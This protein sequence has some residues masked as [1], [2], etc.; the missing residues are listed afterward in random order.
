[1][2]RAATQLTKALLEYYPKGEFH[3]FCGKGN[4]GG[5]G[6]AVA[7]MLFEKEAPVK[8]YVVEHTDNASED[9]KSNLKAASELQIPLQYI[10]S[11]SEIPTVE[12]V[13]VDAL[14]GSGLN[15]PLEGLLKSVVAELNQQSAI[16]VAIDI[17]TG[18]FAD[19]NQENE[20]SAVYKADR[21]LSLQMPKASFFH[22]DTAFQVGDLE[23]L[24]IGLHPGFL[25]DA[26]TRLYYFNREEASL[27]YR[28]RQKHSYKGTYGH[29]LLMAGSEGKNGAALL[30]AKAVMRSG[31][32]LLTVH[33]SK[34]G[35]IPLQTGLPEAMV[36]ADAHDRWITELPETVP[37]SAIGIGPGI[38]QM[39]ETANVL[40]KLIQDAS[41][42]LVIDAD[43][44]N[45]LAENPTWLAFLP[46]GTVLTPHIGE[47]RRLLGVQKLEHD[48]L[49]QLR[50][51]AFKNAI[52]VV[53]KDS[54]TTIASPK[55]DL[56]FINSGSPALATAGSGDVLTGIILGLLAQ[57]YPGLQAA[58]LGTW[59]HGKAASLYAEEEGEESLLASD[60]TEYSGRVFKLL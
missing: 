19:S 9:F 2:E 15:R 39:E 13:I 12:G 58:L 52:T 23:I 31:A 50:E 37:Y 3:I 45:I 46:K 16:R 40:K 53:L 60:I 28:P 51:L 55:G 34:S 26:E 17:P 8:L 20:L 27:L 10:S 30:S 1:M 59:M 44:L 56:H 25:K 24:D 22:R 11:E 48:Y 18:L 42:P 21:T 41:Q 35:V 5:D 7:R 29:A 49:E 38:A 36:S 14:L 33:T 57:G 6:L 43:G 4:N 54:F 47:V 32:G